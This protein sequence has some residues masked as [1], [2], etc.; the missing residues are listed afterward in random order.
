MSDPFVAEIR[1][2]G[3]NFAPTGWA[4]CDGQLLPISQNTALFSL[5]G[6]V[7]GGD[8][9]STFALPDLKDSVPIQQGQ[10]PG[11]SDYALGQQAGVPAITLLTSEMPVHT[12][13]ANASID[14]A[15]FQ[16]P[17]PDR[18]LATSS[19]GFAYQ[20]NDSSSLTT[21][22]PQTL[23]LAGNSLPHNNVQ[24]SLVMNFIIAMQGVFPARP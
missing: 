20:S 23:S 7:Y 24:P 9:K 10:G 22:N 19:P 11:L 5:L 16:A 8:G 14:D 3:F 17:A 18:E 4:F 2:V 6:T 13:Q 1:V 21:M 15:Q 12:H